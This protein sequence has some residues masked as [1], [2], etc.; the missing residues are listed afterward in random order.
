M[1]EEGDVPQE[2]TSELLRELAQATVLKA[3]QEGDRDQD[4]ASG[5]AIEC[6]REI[7]IF[8]YIQGTRV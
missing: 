7:I 3:G 8:G 5:I 1:K 4:R 6:S 2:P